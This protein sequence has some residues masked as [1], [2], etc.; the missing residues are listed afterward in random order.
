MYAIRS[1]YEHHR[2]GTRNYRDAIFSTVINCFLRNTAAH[3]LMNPNNC[4]WSYS[5]EHVLSGTKC[6]KYE[7][8]A[9]KL[10][11]HGDAGANH[12]IK[13]DPYTLNVGNG[14]IAFV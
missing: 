13:L 3:T 7:W 9:A 6:L 10:E 5:D 11:G 2:T 14:E 1:Y 12:G 4:F 8:D